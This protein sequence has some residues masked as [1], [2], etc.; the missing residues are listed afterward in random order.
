MRQKVQSKLSILLILLMITVLFG[1]V[2]LK[3]VQSKKADKIYQDR[4]QQEIAVFEKTIKLVGSSI[5][6][7]TT[8]YTVWDDMI[9]FV[10]NPDRK[11]ALENI[12]FGLNTYGANAIWVYN[13]DFTLIYTTNNIAG[14][15]DPLI[16]PLSRPILKK[17]FEE[18]RECYFF[19]MIQQ[20]LI[21]V[22]GASIHPTYDNKRKTA[23][24]GYFLAAKFWSNSYISEI[25]DLT[26]T[27]ITIEDSDISKIEKK[28]DQ[29]NGLIKFSN[30]LAGW[31]GQPI[32]YFHVTTQ[33]GIVREIN[34][35][36]NFQLISAIILEAL[37]FVILTPFLI[38]WVS[39]PLQLISKA[40]NKQDPSAIAPLESNDTEFGIIAHLIKGFFRQKDELAVAKDNLEL[41]VREMITINKSL[42]KEIE[43]HKK[44][45]AEKG[46]LWSMLLQSEKLAALG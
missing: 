14:A 31:D 38:A 33:M 28:S 25:A 44:A 16:F 39:K 21:S 30:I 41:K 19:C 32:K 3:F 42:E 24:R 18:K 12:D 40:L 22:R 37:I 7:L 43:E 29:K 6:N 4:K 9:S 11:W 10:R 8:D 23:P 26:S 36:S 27:S 17:I 5:K 1:F 34:K 20:G 15:G 13:N 35:S 46:K 45:E 2:Y